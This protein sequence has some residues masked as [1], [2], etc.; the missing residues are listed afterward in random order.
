MRAEAARLRLR[1]EQIASLVRTAHDQARAMTFEGPYA[2]SVET[3]LTRDSRFGHRAAA[4]LA[5]AAAILERS[6][7]E[8]EAAIIAERRR[9]AAL[10]EAE[11]RREPGGP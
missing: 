5:E 2:R 3:D 4:S 9:L 6:A 11:S 10:A 1:A 7:T 8:V